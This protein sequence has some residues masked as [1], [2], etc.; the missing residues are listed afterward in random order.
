ML[1]L[2]LRRARMD[3]QR[4]AS[5]R[6]ATGRVVLA[7]LMSSVVVA[8]VPVE[9]RSAAAQRAPVAVAAERDD[10]FDAADDSGANDGLMA[11]YMEVQT[12]QDEVRRLQGLFEEQKYRVDRLLKEQRDRYIDI[13]RRL[14]ELSR[15]TAGAGEPPPSTDSAAPRSRSSLAPAETD[16]PDERA[17]YAQAIALV[18]DARSATNV[19]RAT[20]FEAAIA[21]FS[22]FLGDYPNGHL[23]PNAYYWLGE[24]HLATDDI[25]LA[26]QNFRQLESLYPDHAKTADALY[27]LGVVYHRLGDAASALR[28]LDR[29]AS[30]F[31]DAD[32]ADLA[33]AYA[34]EL[35]STP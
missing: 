12:L 18:E 26:R 7:L 35:R 29:V 20:L 23:T 24:L 8:A 25:E 5:R 34:A 6:F 27:K 2:S 33:R 31:P 28:Y 30:E 10:G 3:R 17:A 1:A 15:Q 19:E 22:A 9:D 32:S 14:L 13:D 16:E 21:R 4:V 11:L